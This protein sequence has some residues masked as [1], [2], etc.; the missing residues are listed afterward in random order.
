MA[1]KVPD[2]IPPGEI[3]VEE[4]MKPL[5]VSILE[6]GARWLTCVPSCTP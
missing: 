1:K 4:F 2:P 6:P 5:G 3:L